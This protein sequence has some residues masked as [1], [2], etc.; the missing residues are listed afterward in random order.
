MVIPGG[1]IALSGVKTLVQKTIMLATKSSIEAWSQR[2]ADEFFEAFCRH[3]AV[4]EATDADIG[5]DLNNVL[6]S[7]T[8]QRVLFD[9]YRSVCLCRSR[10]L[11]PRVIA[12][13]T[14][15]LVNEKREANDVEDQLL[16]AA[17]ELTDDELRGLAEHIAKLERVLAGTPR[18]GEKGKV[19]KEFGNNVVESIRTELIPTDDASSSGGHVSLAPMNLAVEVG[20]WAAKLERV[21]LVY[22]DMREKPYVVKEDSERHIDYDHHYRDVHWLMVYTEGAKDLAVLVSQADTVM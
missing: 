4:P 22:G 11:G 18:P 21:G 12:I 7:E 16:A 9:A 10:M 15:R 13:L 6:G 19:W 1:A 20:L 3:V 17:E 14:A 2:R 5:I 8:A